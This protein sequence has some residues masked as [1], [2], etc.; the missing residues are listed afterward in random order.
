MLDLPFPAAAKTG[1]TT[2]WRDNWTIGYSSRRLVGVWVG[3]ADNTPMEGITGIDGAGPIWRD[4]ML[5]SHSEPPPPFTRPARIKELTICAPSGLLPSPD[6]PRLRRERFIA[7]TEPTQE[8]DQ[9]VRV[10][11]D[12]ATGLRAG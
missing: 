12:L 10:P 6:C 4:V 8:D 7:G 5:A 1:T 3:N 11:I 2:D 9:F